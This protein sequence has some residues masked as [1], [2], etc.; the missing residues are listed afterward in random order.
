MKRTIL[1]RFA[2]IFFICLMIAVASG[3]IFLPGRAE[4][5][6][7]TVMEMAEENKE[8]G[9]KAGDAC[10]VD[11][12]EEEEPQEEAAKEQAAK[13]QAAKEQAVEEQTAE[14]QWEQW[15]KEWSIEKQIYPLLE[16]AEEGSREDYIR[17]GL[18]DSDIYQV[19]EGDTL[20]GIAR[21]CYGKGTDWDAIKQENPGI[22]GD[23][24]LI[25]PD[26][27]LSIPQFCYIRKQEDSL[28]GFSSPA[29]TYDIPSDWIYGYPKWETCVEYYWPDYADVGVFSH[30]TENRM[31]PEHMGGEWEEMQRKITA[32][33]EK[34][35]RVCFREL[36]FSRYK[37][38]DGREL[39]FYRFIC[40]SEEGD[41]RCAVA[42]TSGENY[43]AEFIGHCPV[44]KDGGEPAFD[45]EG[46]TRY[47]AA[48]YEERGGEKNWGSLKYRP[49]LGYENWPYE[50]L[51]NPFAM[52]ETIYVVE[53]D[54]ELVGK[55]E[56]V[57]FVSKEWENLLRKV[58]WVHYDLTEEQMEEFAQRPIY[59]SELAWITEVVFVESPIPGRDEVS[60]NGFYSEGATCAEY[61]LTTLQDL[62][63]LP[64][65]HKLT[66]ETGGADDYEALGQCKALK[67][68]SIASQEPVEELELEWAMELG[69]LESLTV[70]VSNFPHLIEIGYEK[71]GATTFGNQEK[72]EEKA[73]GAGDGKAADGEN[74]TDEADKKESGGS[75]KIEEVLAQCTSLKYLKL[76]YTEELDLG[77]LGKLPQLY[78]FWL[79][80]EK[81]ESEAA[82][83]RQAL[84]KDEDWPQIKCLVVDGDWLRNP[85]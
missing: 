71:E 73:E 41:V 84:F 68:V 48:S 83:Q 5:R 40:E 45:I 2:R 33:A 16:N 35:E 20:W 9:Q 21:E 14:E 60:V 44:P 63:V 4:G 79:D 50:D 64:N 13:E 42:Y 65:L 51:H 15:Q 72:G 55:D 47:I 39:F 1:Y 17:L 34:V 22:P 85:E 82:M 7:K 66:L 59:A 61:N 24:S 23:G 75:M 29:C 70:T 58:I 27:E 78:T 28:G 62:A 56:E 69:Q 18:E 10:E 67:E 19:R 77:F 32:S 81:M 80:G 12:K 30:V 37:K 52:M 31:F 36:E 38:E 6:K 11:S 74:A 46:I 54:E 53:E 25:F 8:T 3:C 57:H 43:M 26:M 49:Y 76:E